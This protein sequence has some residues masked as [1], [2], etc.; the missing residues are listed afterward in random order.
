[1]LTDESM[2]HHYNQLLRVFIFFEGFRQFLKN[3]ADMASL[4]LDSLLPVLIQIYLGDGA[5]DHHA[6]GYIS[7]CLDF[8]D[9]PD[10]L[11]MQMDV[12]SD[13][14]G[15]CVRT[16]SPVVLEEVQTF[17]ALLERNVASSTPTS[18]RMGGGDVLSNEVRPRPA[19]IQ[20]RTIDLIM[21]VKT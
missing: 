14:V 1:M 2:G 7:T 10:S 11:R 16:G 8:S 18:W 6:I 4:C 20:I 9:I 13:L 5:L 17:G 15:Y 21:V 12:Y 3:D 19:A